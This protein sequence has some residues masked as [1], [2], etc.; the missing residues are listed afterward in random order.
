MFKARNRRE[1]QGVD[2]FTILKWT[3]RICGV[4]RD[5]LLRVTDTAFRQEIVLKALLLLLLL[6]ANG[7]IPYS[8]RGVSTVQ[9]KNTHYMK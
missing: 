2:E 8:T 3:A 5:Q 6:L 4:D 1:Y 9:Y 7:F